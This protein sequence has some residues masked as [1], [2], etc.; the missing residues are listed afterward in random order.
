[1]SYVSLVLSLMRLLEQGLFWAVAI[2]AIVGVI[3]ALRMRED[4]FPAGDRQPKM[5]W[6]GMLAG[7]AIVLVFLPGL[8][9]LPWIA[10][11]MVGL[12]W[13]DV[14]PQLKSLVNGDYNY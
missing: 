8:M 3:F 12:F 9:F 1:M 7:S 2:A 11:V 6:V 10:A 4:A 14:Y 13:F 5:V